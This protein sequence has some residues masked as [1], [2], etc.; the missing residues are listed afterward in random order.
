MSAKLKVFQVLE[1]GGGGGTGNQVAWLCNGLDPQRFEAGLIYAVRDGEDPEQYRSKA[2]GAFSIYYMPEMT[3]EI[4][5]WRDFKSLLKLYRIFREQKPDI[6]HAHSSK[7]GFLAR[8]A[9]WL[10]GVPKIFYTPHGYGFLQLD[11]PACSRS[12]Y[13]LLEWLVSWIGEIIAVS[14]SEAALAQKLSWGKPVHLVCDPYLGK[15]PPG[16]LLEHSGVVIGSCGRMTAA[17]NTGAFVN[18]CRGLGRSRQDIKCVWIGGGGEEPSVK[19]A[20]AGK[21]EVTGWLDCEQARER[22]RG[23]DILAHY[24]RWDGLPNAVLEAMALGLPVVASEVPGCRDCVIH[25]ETGYLARNESEL[26][27]YCLKLADSPALRKKLGE[28]GR[29]L[30][31]E[32][33]NRDS[34]LRRLEQTYTR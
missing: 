11:R 13:R 23:L 19:S 4:S 12:F 9:A 16:P 7:A 1:C 25:G 26:L 2:S 10:A 21:A 18:L 14:P 28:A 32:R 15:M 34:A 8:T 20:L 30:V 22:L 3:R 29:Q 24:S 17:R 27:E 31:V 33:F 5:P 6:A